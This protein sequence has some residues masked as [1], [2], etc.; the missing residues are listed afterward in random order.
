MSVHG[1]PAACWFVAASHSSVSGIQA[2]LHKLELLL[3][4]FFDITPII[5]CC[6]PYVCVY[7]EYLNVED[8]E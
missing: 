5:W 1:L 3:L 7:M 2:L 8:G 4:L 6:A